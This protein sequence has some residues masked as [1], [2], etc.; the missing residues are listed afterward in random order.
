M[1][2]QILTIFLGSLLFA[3]GLV[4]LIGL[5]RLAAGAAIV[6]LSVPIALIVFV[7]ALGVL[8]YRRYGG[9]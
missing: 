2:L 9:G 6:A 4:S 5:R 3:I 1:T 8:V 7:V